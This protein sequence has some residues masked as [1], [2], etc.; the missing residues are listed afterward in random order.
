M[1][2]MNCMDVGRRLQSYLDDELD[3]DRM[4]RIRE[5]LDACVDCGLDLDVYAR[6][7][8]E[9]AAARSDPDPSVIDSL[10]HFARNISER[11]EATT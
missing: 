8:A 2:M 10:R 7:K 11:H 5:H 6:I 1:A 4:D 3:S 9:L